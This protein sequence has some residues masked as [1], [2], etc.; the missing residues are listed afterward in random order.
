VN[1]LLLLPFLLG[2]SAFFSA[3]E[4]ALFS[5]SRADLSRLRGS[6]TRAARNTLELLE[7]PGNLLVAVLFGNLLVNFLLYAVAAHIIAGLGKHAGPGS[8]VLGAVVSTGVVIVCGEVG[9]KSLAVTRPLTVALWTATPLHTFGTVSRKLGLTTPLQRMVGALLWLIE[10]RLPKPQG[11]LSDDELRRFV[12]IQGERGLIERRSSEFLAEALELRSRRAH[13]VMTPR[14]DLVA[15]DAS[16]SRGAFLELIREHRVGKVLVHTGDGLDKVRGY[17]RTRDVLA[18]PGAALEELIQ[19]CWFVPHTKSLESLLH[20]MIERQDH[21]ALVVGEYGG[22]EGVITLEDIVEE[23]TGDIARDDAPPLL[24]RLDEGTWGISGRFP[25]RDVAELLG[26][27]VPESS[28]TTLAGFVTHLLDRIPEVGD[29]VWHAGVQFRVESVD[30]RRA[31]R[32][33]IALPGSAP[34]RAPVGHDPEDAMT[35]SGA[36]RANDRL[37]RFIAESAPEQE[38]ASS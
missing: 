29:V 11:T 22:T 1:G 17:L 15:C 2:L 10:T 27:K 12:A 36:H 16:L 5:L 14:V 33:R 34:R 35:V 21:L 20:E 6:T 13:E 30:R 7:H 26:L 9:P 31:T 3:S 19:P 4:T 23:I 37:T 8:Y 18:Q 38:E 25:L 28:L 32:V 24:E